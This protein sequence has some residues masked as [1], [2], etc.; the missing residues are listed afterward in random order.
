MKKWAAIL[1]G[2]AMFATAVSGLAA[3]KPAS[4]TLRADPRAADA[5]TAYDHEGTPVGSYKTIADAINATVT[6]DLDY[7][8]DDAVPNATK[9]GYVTR[10]D[11][12]RHLFENKKGYTENYDDQY[13][14]YE[15]GNKLAGYDAWD[16]NPSMTFLRNNKMV[17]HKVT[18]YGLTPVQ[19]WN[20]YGLID[21]YGDEDTKSDNPASWALGTAIDAGV[22][23][24]PSSAGGTATGMSRDTYKID[25]TE[26]RITPPYDGTADEVYAYLGFYIWT[27]QYVL[28]IGIGCNTKTGK[29]YEFRGT[30]R[31]DSF[32]DVE[33]DLGDCLLESTWDEKNGCFTP[34]AKELEISVQTVKMV[35]EEFG[36]EYFVCRFKADIRG[37][38]KDVTLNRLIDD[39][40]MAPYFSERI[41][42]GN[43]FLFIAGLDIKNPVATGVKVKNVDYFNGAKLEGLCVTEAGVYFPTEE[44]ISDDDFTEL[45]LDPNL[46]GNTYDFLLANDLG[47]EGNYGYT[48]LSNYMCTTYTAKD[49][50]DY[51]D[52]RFDGDPVGE[53]E[54]GGMLK[55][56]QEKIDSLSAMTVENYLDYLAAYEEAGKWYGKDETHEDSTLGDMYLNLLDFSTYLAAKEVYLDAM[57]LSTEGQE[58]LNS[59]NKLGL[60]TATNYPYQGWTRDAEHQ[61]DPILGWFWEE[62]QEFDRIRT[63][64]HALEQSEQTKVMNLYNSEKEGNFEDWA[65]AYDSVKAYLDNSDY[66]SKSYTVADLLMN[67]KDITY[68]GETALQKLLAAAFRIRQNFWPPASTTSEEPYVFNSDNTDNYKAAFHLLFLRTKMEEAGVELPKFFED[69]LELITNTPRSGNFMMDFDEYLYPVLTLAGDIYKKKQAGTFVWLDENMADIVNEYMIDFTFSE[70]GFAWN[71]TNNHDLRHVDTNYERYFG[72]P[73]EKGLKPNIQYIIDVVTECD[74]TAEVAASG[75]AFKKEVKPLENDPT[76]NGSEQAKAVWAEIEKL[77]VL[78][79]YTYKGWTTQNADKA[80]YLY[81]EIEAFRALVE[82]REALTN[83]EK[84]YVNAQLA[85]A[86][87]AAQNAN[88]KAWETL[89]A[90]MATLE[91]HA[92]W[93]KSFETFVKAKGTDTKT[94]KA[95]EALAELI[96]AAYQIK[97]VGKVTDSGD[98]VADPGKIGVNNNFRSTARLVSFYDFFMTNGAPLPTFVTAMTDALGLPDYYDN[99]FYPLSGMVKLAVRIHTAS[100]TKI[101]QLTEEELEYLNT[102]WVAGY[103]MKGALKTHWWANNGGTEKYFAWID[104]KLTEQ[105][106]KMLG[107]T[108]TEKTLPSDYV[109]YLNDFLTAAHYTPNTARHG[110]GVTQATIYASDLSDKLLQ[111]AVALEKLSDLDTYEAKGWKAPDSTPVKG[112]LYSEAQYY[113]TTVAPLVADLDRTESESL[114]LLF[115]AD[116]LEEWAS[117]SEDVLALPE[118]KTQLTIHAAESDREAAKPKDYTVGESLGE[119]LSAIAAANAAGELLGFDSGIDKG[120]SFRPYFFYFMLEELEVEIPEVIQDRMDDVKMEETAAAKFETDVKYIM[121]I[122]RLARAI[123][124]DADHK[125]TA[126]EI[127]LVNDNLVGKD[128]FVD[129]GFKYAYVNDTKYGDPVSWHG[130]SKGYKAYFGFDAKQDF[131][132]Y[133]K[134]VIDYLVAKYQATALMYTA[135]S[136]SDP[137]LPAGGVAMGITAA[138]SAQN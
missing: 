2:G 31:D 110:W 119:L 25:L 125:L 106:T 93:E 54:L 9:G 49:G 63:A 74:P 28:A 37:G 127:K 104:Y 50:A 65:N 13:W 8:E 138:I 72:L 135:P 48:I 124:D 51:Y 21:E 113:T 73:D 85:L 97:T 90:E 112:Y 115:G 32:S 44:E 6:A 34:N 96:S 98:D 38:K 94:Y 56:Y 105:F 108:E 22:M 27:P 88:Y 15:D 130:K 67:G 61:N 30:S 58:V 60:V 80:G 3:C 83:V 118:D 7:F 77:T 101:S 55:E 128:R 114:A 17:V 39:E 82:K 24:F 40:L 137:A 29:W 26:M 107:G 84:A 76:A 129:G 92:V 57:H 103:E 46:R 42:T 43:D 66:T 45:N 89:S 52:F 100:L 10:K 133:Q 33:Y 36:E 95:D 136:G 87:H 14:F 19:S 78:D 70:A 91:E 71:F 86:A 5:Y 109:A 1:L 79:G 121:T 123:T 111:I 116:T 12:T 134:L 122:M 120:V 132:V 75:I 102:Y 68:T 126:A 16:E 11:G 81:S 64:L 4:V 20:G 59:L 47:S 23:V 99:F 131:K 53:T 41:H 35:D 62:A 18:G 69:M 117:L